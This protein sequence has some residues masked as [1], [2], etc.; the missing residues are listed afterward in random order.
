MYDSHPTEDINFLFVDL[1]RFRDSA[2]CSR[3]RND[4][5]QGMGFTKTMRQDRQLRTEGAVNKPSPG[6]CMEAGFR[7]WQLARVDAIIRDGHAASDVGEN[8]K[9]QKERHGHISD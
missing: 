8:K 1:S 4:I 2:T 3:I 5:S 9:K 6:N 7:R